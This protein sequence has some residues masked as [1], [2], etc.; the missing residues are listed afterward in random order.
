VLATKAGALGTVTSVAASVP[1]FLSIAGS[2]ITSSG[3]LAIT[4]SGTAL[5]T[6]SGG[7]GL[8]SFTA[9]GVVYASS[10]SVL[11]TG[12]ALVFDG[13]NLGL[14]VTP[15]AWAVAYAALQLKNSTSISSYSSNDGLNLCSNAYASGSNSWKYLDASSYPAA[16]YEIGNGAHNWYN[17]A[18][19]TAGNA[20]IFTQAMTLDASGNLGVGTTSPA[21]KLDVNG[22]ISYNGAIGEG[23]A[24][25]VSSSSTNL[26]FGQSSTW[27]T[28]LFYTN[29]A[30]RAR[31]DSGGN[32]LLKATSA[33]TSAVGVLGM[34]NATAPSS[35]PAGMGQL[36]VEGGALKYRG[37]SGTVTTIAAA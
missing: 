35:S 10:S 20:I 29:G 2:P 33:G 22:R 23:A 12:S 11:T 1:S 14:G 13:T 24:T 27:Q 5:P 7:T 19:G 31:I 8:T 28:N 18:S 3:T 6:T 17:A 34:G 15:S 37:S 9:N 30:E 36:Y 4:L 25:T 16:R 21:Y 26:I 32:L